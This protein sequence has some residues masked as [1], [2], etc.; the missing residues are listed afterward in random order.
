MLA[1]VSVSL[2]GLTVVNSLVHIVM[3]SGPLDPSHSV[4]H[5]SHPKLLCAGQVCILSSD[6]AWCPTPRRDE[7]TNHSAAGEG[8]ARLG[9]GVLPTQ[10][11]MHPDA[12]RLT[13]TRSPP[14]ALLQDLSIQ[15]RR[16]W[17]HVLLCLLLP[18]THDP[19]QMAA[20]YLHRRLVCGHGSSSR[21]PG[22]DA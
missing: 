16:F 11:C 19:G 22:V 8:C 18:A 17:W 6:L 2:V 10:F 9:G 20:P 1:G 3:C 4:P 15:P 7:K 12:L 13:L 21:R 14:A 5:R